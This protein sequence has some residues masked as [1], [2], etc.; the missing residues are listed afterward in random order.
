MRG[1]RCSADGLREA[2]QSEHSLV[3]V[4][5]AFIYCYGKEPGFKA[6]FATEFFQA[7]K[8]CEE[9][10]LSDVFDVSGP[11]KQPISQES[12]LGGILLDNSLESRFVASV[13]LS[14][15]QFIINAFGHD[16]H[17]RATGRGII[18]EKKWKILDGR[19]LGD[20]AG[21]LGDGVGIGATTWGRPYG[22]LFQA[23]CFSQF[24]C[25]V[26]FLPGEIWEVSSEVSAV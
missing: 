24:V 22:I 19:G 20:D 2:A 18:T 10:V 13:E 6:A 15:Q 3:S 9:G 21:F 5:S 12:Y 11:A 7:E 8:R 23:C 1:R 25:H 14:D 16:Y 4:C 26:R 17:I